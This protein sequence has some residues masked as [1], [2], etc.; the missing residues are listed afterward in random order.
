VIVNR[1]RM[2]FMRVVWQLTPTIG[3]R[4]PLANWV[5]R[6]GPVKIVAPHPAEKHSGAGA[7]LFH[8]V[9]VI[10]FIGVIESKSASNLSGNSLAVAARM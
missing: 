8:L 3:Q 1:C 4:P 2:D 7:L 10:S 5:E 6:E 9:S